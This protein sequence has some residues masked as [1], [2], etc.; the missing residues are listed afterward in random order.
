[1]FRHRDRPHSRPAA[2]V[3]NAKS[4]VQIEMADVGAIVGR[5]RKSDLRVEICSVE[6]NLPAIRVYDLANR[7]D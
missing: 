7:S 6:I 1:M 5:A 4:L 3:G 2:A